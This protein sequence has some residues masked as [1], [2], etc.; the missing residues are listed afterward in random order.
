MIGDSL[1]VPGYRGGPTKDGPVQPVI[2]EAEAN[3]IRALGALEV[4]GDTLPHPI[5]PE[6]RRLASEY[7]QATMRAVV[8]RLSGAGLTIGMDTLED[9]F[10]ALVAAEGCR[11]AH[12][13]SPELRGALLD[14]LREHPGGARVVRALEKY[15][16]P[17][18]KPPVRPERRD[19]PGGTPALPPADIGVPP[20]PSGAVPGPVIEGDPV[21]ITV[22]T[23]V[24]AAPNSGL[25]AGDAIPT[26]IPQGILS[27]NTP[28]E[29]RAQIAEV[30]EAQQAKANVAAVAE[31][32]RRIVEESWPGTRGVTKALLGVGDFMGGSRPRIV[33]APLPGL[34]HGMP[35]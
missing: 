10:D 19:P 24:G 5:A 33:A 31:E 14:R 17:V 29:D 20:K 4:N 23:R 6:L 26:M 28:A 35:A 9:L 22:E 21:E 13:S 2:T 30:L 25:A 3:L 11:T 15:A 34:P 18:G 16:P 1:F 27:H 12:P 8:A 7:R 32:N